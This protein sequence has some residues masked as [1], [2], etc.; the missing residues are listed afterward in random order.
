MFGVPASNLYGNSFQVVLL[1][2]DVADHVAARLVRRHQFQ[3]LR[4]AVEDADAGRAVHLVPG[5]D[6]EIAVQVL[7]IDAQMRHRLGAVD[8][9]DNAVL[10]GE[11][12]DFLDRIDRAQG[13]GDV[14][15]RR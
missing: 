12:D 4:L 10:V 14:G 6:V 5:E 13:V 11:L 15:Q 9:D 1:E 8:E 3:M 2:A 7:H